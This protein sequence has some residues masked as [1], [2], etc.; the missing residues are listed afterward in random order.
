M[1]GFAKGLPILLPS[2]KLN[3][4]TFLLA[5]AVAYNPTLEP[6]DEKLSKFIE[7]NP[8]RLDGTPR[9]SGILDTVRAS[10]AHGV[11]MPSE[12]RDR[13]NIDLIVGQVSSRLQ[14]ITHLDS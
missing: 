5:A 2:S 11:N 7:G 10:A 6:L 12:L 9:A 13:K 3:E 14:T 8:V 4:H 1:L